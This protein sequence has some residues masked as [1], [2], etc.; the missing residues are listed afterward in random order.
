MCYR[1]LREEKCPSNPQDMKKVR[2]SRQ[3][4]T[5]L[6]VYLLRPDTCEDQLKLSSMAD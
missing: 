5:T 4:R 3:G 2:Q 6:E 1:I